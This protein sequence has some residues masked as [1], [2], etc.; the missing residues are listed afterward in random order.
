MDFENICLIASGV[1]VLSLT[2]GAST[3]F[4]LTVERLFFVQHP[5]LQEVKQTFFTKL[6]LSASIVNAGISLVVAY[7]ESKD[8]MMCFTLDISDADS[9]YNILVFVVTGVYVSLLICHAI[10]SLGTILQFLK[11]KKQLGQVVSGRIKLI[12]KD[13]VVSMS[14]LVSWIVL[15]MVFVVGDDM[16]SSYQASFIVEFLLP[17]NSFL[18][19]VLKTFATQ[20][21]LDK[22][23]HK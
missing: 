13:L 2:V 5:H 18:N 3:V 1:A 10:I 11:G 21:F 9:V 7:Y 20:Q 16:Y 19:P 14:P 8:K 15:G 22:V 23:F 4:L 12:I 6:L 17:F